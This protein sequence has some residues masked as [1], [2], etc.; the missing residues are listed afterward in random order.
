MDC[1]FISSI[2]VYKFPSS[3]S[4]TTNW[5]ENIPSFSSSCSSRCYLFLNTN[6]NKVLK[7][8]F[9]ER[10]LLSFI[11]Q[12]S[13]NSEH[14]QNHFSVICAIFC[15]ST[16]SILYYGLGFA[17]YSIHTQICPSGNTREYYLHEDNL[18]KPSTPITRNVKSYLRLYRNVHV[19][20]CQ[21]WRQGKVLHSQKCLLFPL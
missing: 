16:S 18:S 10:K 7:T 9:S 2:C 8:N 12:N 17:A 19:Y 14:S 11:I 1:V 5:R 4:S 3:C 13:Q 20:V 15:L 21:K 6:C